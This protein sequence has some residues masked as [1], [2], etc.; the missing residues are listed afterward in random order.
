MSLVCFMQAAWGGAW[1]AISF[2]LAVSFHFLQVCPLLWESSCSV[3]GAYFHGSITF[4]G[5]VRA[6]GLIG[7]Y[8]TTTH[9]SAATHVV[10]GYSFIAGPPTGSSVEVRL[11]L[12]LSSEPVPT[13]LVQ[14]IRGGHFVEMHDLLGDNITLTQHFELAANYF[15]TVLPSSVRSRLREVSS[16]PSWV[17]CFL[18]Y[19]AV[20]VQDQTVRDRLVYARLIIFSSPGTR[21]DCPGLPGVCQTDRAWGTLPR[22]AEMVRLWPSFLAAGSIRPIVTLWLYTSQPDGVHSTE[23]TLRHRV[24]LWFVPGLWPHSLRLCHDL[25]PAPS[26][27]GSTLKI[28]PDLI[29]LERQSCCDPRPVFD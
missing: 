28:H 10:R 16:I 7:Y 14:R 9:H 19:L 21:P 11:G 17:Y 15:P 12:S 2:S 5:S 20:L 22:R 1:L 26:A 4:S 29:V 8:L 18:T 23:P 24:I 25:A 27:P 13:R 3:G 6:I